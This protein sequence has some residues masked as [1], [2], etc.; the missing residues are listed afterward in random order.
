MN[1]YL[2]R[3][4]W[5]FLVRGI[6]AVILGLLA[7]LMPATT[8]AVFVLIIGVYMFIDG[9]FTVASAIGSRKTRPNWGWWLFSG[10]MGILIGVIT[11]YNPFVTAF[12]IVM[13]I[14]AW[15]IVIGIMEIIWAIQ[16]R[17]EIRGEGWYILAGALSLLFGL[18][19]FFIPEAGVVLLTVL[20]G[21]YALIIG[22]MLIVIG[23]R[24]KKKGKG[25]VN[26]PV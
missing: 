15:A 12:A 14:A 11:F 3:F 17:K 13:L 8:F 24:V 26:L 9:L 1:S 25:A 7:L 5:L 4:W 23:V 2:T 10:I 22:I 19:V 20:F 16:I 18:M 21:L 6:F